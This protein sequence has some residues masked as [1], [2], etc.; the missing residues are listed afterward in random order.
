LRLKNLP[1]SSFQLPYPTKI[2]CLFQNP[3]QLIKEI[4]IFAGK[5]KEI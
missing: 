4:S 3:A 2:K 1:S 5:E